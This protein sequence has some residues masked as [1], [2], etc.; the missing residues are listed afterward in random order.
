MEN[1]DDIVDAEIV[2]C[3]YCHR[4]AVGIVELVPESLH[5]DR[6]VFVCEGCYELMVDIMA[7][8]EIAVGWAEAGGR[9]VDLLAA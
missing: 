1:D 6:H 4:T 2:E 3:F 8:I 9:L 5:P 7:D